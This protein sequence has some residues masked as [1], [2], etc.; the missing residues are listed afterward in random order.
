MIGTLFGGSQGLSRSIFGQMIPE[1]RSTEFF[2]FFGFFGKVAAVGP[3]LYATM[4]VMFDSR[5]GSSQ[6]S[7]LNCNRRIPDE[8]R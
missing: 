6:Y 3:F 5:V 7:C 8:V 1:T 2:G 4:T